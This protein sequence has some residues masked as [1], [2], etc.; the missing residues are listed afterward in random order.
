MWINFLALSL[1]RFPLGTSLS[2]NPLCPFNELS[3]LAARNNNVKLS[4]QFQQIFLLTN[5]VYL[6]K[7]SSLKANATT[8]WGVP[9]QCS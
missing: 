4:V 9:W 1:V 5:L 3:P 7:P 8:R 6:T 2:S